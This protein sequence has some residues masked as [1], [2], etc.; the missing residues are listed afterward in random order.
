MSTFIKMTEIWTG[1]SAL[2][3]L[4]AL[5]G[6]TVTSSFSNELT[7]CVSAM[8]KRFGRS[9]VRLAGF[10]VYCFIP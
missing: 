5:F 1:L 3:L 10:A 2:L 7:V 8:P 9:N 4:P 6:V